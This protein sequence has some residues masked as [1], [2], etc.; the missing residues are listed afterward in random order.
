MRQTNLDEFIQLEEQNKQLEKKVQ[1]EVEKNRQKEQILFHQSKLA[2]MGEML[3]SIAHQWRQPLMEINSLFIPIEA[4]LKSN[5]SVDNEEIL[6]SIKKLN[7]ITN[8]MSN[9]INDFRNFFSS[10]K[11]AIKFNLSTQ[12]NSAINI[13]STSLKQNNINLEIIVKKNPEVYGIKSEYSQVLINIINNAKEML[14]F[15]KTPNPLIKIT[16]DKKEDI[17]I[18]KIEDNA[19]GIKLRNIDDVLNLFIQKRKKMAQA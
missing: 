13:L 4:Q 9:T 7:D 17:A 5:K 11:Q 8:Y 1:Q 6:N 3:S 12:I 14:I 2:S 18:I 15:R 19:G 16:I 10:N